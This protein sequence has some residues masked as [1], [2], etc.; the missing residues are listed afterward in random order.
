MF[1]KHKFKLEMFVAICWGVG[2]GCLSIVRNT[3]PLVDQPED[4]GSD[5]GLCRVSFVD[6][7]PAL[8]IDFYVA[9]NGKLFQK[10]IS[11]I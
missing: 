9:V 4:K 10:K 3:V 6:F 8:K 2:K 7:F 5:L 1:S 11:L